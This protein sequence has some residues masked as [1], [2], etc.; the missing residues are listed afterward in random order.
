MAVA[1]AGRRC[2]HMCSD[3]RKGGRHR[4]GAIK[5]T[6]DDAAKVSPLRTR[7]RRRG[8]GDR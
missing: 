1:S 2:N 6:R 3:V 8:R 7:A 4:L 5:A